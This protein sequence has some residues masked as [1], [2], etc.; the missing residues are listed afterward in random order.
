MFVSLDMAFADEFGYGG[1]EVSQGKGASKPYHVAFLFVWIQW[2]VLD[3]VLVKNAPVKYWDSKNVQ[4]LGQFY[5]LVPREAG[6]V[7]PY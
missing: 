4:E 2:E 6:V 7:F 5:G 1:R 3:S